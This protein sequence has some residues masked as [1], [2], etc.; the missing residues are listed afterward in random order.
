MG[1]AFASARVNCQETRIDDAKRSS[2]NVLEM[3]RAKMQEYQ[4]KRAMSNLDI[5]REIFDLLDEK[6]KAGGKYEELV[7][8][9]KSPDF[10]IKAGT[11]KTMMSKIRA[12]RRIERAQCPCCHTDV[13][14][15]Q[16]TVQYRDGVTRQSDRLTEA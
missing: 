16:I 8:L 3:L 6:L 9:M 2:K 12:E 14:S 15:S 5:I 11:L 10:D 13:P 1:A 4:P 7:E